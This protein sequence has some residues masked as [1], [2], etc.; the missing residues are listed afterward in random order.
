M[1]DY[2]NRVC[3]KDRAKII[4]KMIRIGNHLRLLLK[5]SRVI[6]KC[7]NF[8]QPMALKYA[9]STSQ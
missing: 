4:I 1:R 6:T 3:Y 5:P 2:N 8:P 7:F 9:M